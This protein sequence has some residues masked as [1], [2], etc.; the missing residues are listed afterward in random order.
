MGRAEKDP[1]K[2][3]HEGDPD[4]SVA[5]SSPAISGSSPAA[6]RKAPMKPTKA[7]TSTS[8][9]R[10]RFGQRQPVQHFAGFEPAMHLPPHRC[11]AT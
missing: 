6:P 9:A 5:P 11:W 2:A 7:S 10:R 8:G 3:G 4:V 1:E